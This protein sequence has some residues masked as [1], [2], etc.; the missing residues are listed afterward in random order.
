MKKALFLVLI[1]FVA[2]G[3]LSAFTLSNSTIT[4]GVGYDTIS[5]PGTRYEADADFIS[6]AT[7]ISGFFFYDV[8]LGEKKWFSRIEYDYILFKGDFVF[9]DMPYSKDS[10]YKVS[11]SKNRVGTYGLIEVG[12]KVRLSL[13]ICGVNN[14]ITMTDNEHGIKLA[15]VYTGIGLIADCQF[16]FT[17]KLS[18][19]L[20]LSPDFTFVVVD[21]Y[22]SL[23]NAYEET[24]SKTVF[25]TG[26]S[27]GARI[28]VSYLF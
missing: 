13:G 7:G 21:K 27:M 10:G 8:Q 17:D 20:S 16:M 18:A 6:K 26:F 25:R 28:G 2:I 24:K 15:N 1:L 23:D 12:K 22:R 14:T 19:R 11:A 4:V 3:F 5:G 9:K